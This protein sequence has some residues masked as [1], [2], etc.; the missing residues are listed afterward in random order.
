EF[1]DMSL[2]INAFGCG[3]N[4]LSV[5]IP[6]FQ[7]GFFALFELIFVAEDHLR[8]VRQGEAEIYPG[9]TEVQ[10]QITI[11]AKGWHWKR[12]IVA[13]GIVIVAAPFLETATDE[14]ELLLLKRKFDLKIFIG[15][16][17]VSFDGKSF[18]RCDMLAG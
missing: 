6:P 2:L 9:S 3:Q 18:V 1:Q 12:T 11:Q 7:G 13:T 4:C 5:Y 14:T 10:M 15:N 17:D 8:P 16:N